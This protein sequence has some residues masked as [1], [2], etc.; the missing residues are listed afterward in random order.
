MNTTLNPR[1]SSKK[2]FGGA[3]ALP[4]AVSSEAASSGVWVE[5]MGDDD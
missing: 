1:N 4:V 3:G 5:L 2:G